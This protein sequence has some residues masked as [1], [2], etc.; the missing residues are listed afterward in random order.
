MAKKNINFPSEIPDKIHITDTLDLHG[1]FPEQIPKIINDFIENA[2][3]LKLKHLKIIHGKGKSRLK[4]EVYQ[5]L[6][7][8]PNVGEFKNAPPDQGGWG[9][10]IVFLNQ[11]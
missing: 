5:I 3:A 1:F 6:K 7:T 4:F 10:T 11:S 8:H 9:S 2:S